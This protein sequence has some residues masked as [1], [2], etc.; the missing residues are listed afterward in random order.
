[1]TGHK[2]FNIVAA[3]WDEE[4]RRVQLAT[5]IAAAIRARVPLSVDWQA[6]DF[7]CGTG[8]LTL[9]LAP[10]L[11][12]IV[13]ADSAPGMLEQLECKLRKLQTGTVS[14]LLCDL[15]RD[16][17]PAGPFDLVVSAMTLHHIPQIA[18]LLA[19]VRSR[20]RPGGWIALADLEPEDG[21]FHPD[22]AGVFH[23]GFDTN[24][25]GGLLAAAGFSEITLG[26]AAT[27]L[28]GAHSYP[29][30]LAVGRAQ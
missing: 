9:Q 11:G 10:G 23:H 21:S 25:I 2:D 27:V 22:G 30:F 18:P 8:L 1:M 19:A 14:T 12:S 29:V 5:E 4:P 26:T 24:E 28:K 13:A 20:M 15:E 16:E 17:L 6:L 3:A 7:G